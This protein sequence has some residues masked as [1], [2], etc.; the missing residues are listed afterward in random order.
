MRSLLIICIIA[1]TSSLSLAQEKT[2]VISEWTARQIV[3]DLIE[4]DNARYSLSL[5]DSLLH[6]YVMKNKSD[7]VAI[8]HYKL[9]IEEYKQIIALEQQKGVVVKEAYEEAL[10]TSNKDKVKKFFAGVLIG[11]VLVWIVTVFAK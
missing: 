4:L 2:V 9:T 8:F 5:K 7:S 10:Q 3:K 6:M 1:I 11:G